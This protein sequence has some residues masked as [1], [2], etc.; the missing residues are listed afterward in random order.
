MQ[1]WSLGLP[2]QAWVLHPENVLWTYIP[3]ASDLSL[4][5]AAGRRLREVAEQSAVW[6]DTAE[7]GI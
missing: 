5:K 4:P 7:R 2:A 3:K 1:S 6:G